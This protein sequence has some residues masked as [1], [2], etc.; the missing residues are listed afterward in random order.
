MAEQNDDEK[1]KNRFAPL[2]A[3]L[4]EKQD[5]ILREIDATRG[6]P[7]DIGGYYNPE[8]EKVTRAMRPSQTFNQILADFQ[9]N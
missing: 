5:E 4:A 7:L 2:A 9:Q 8:K 6:K 3:K 1:L